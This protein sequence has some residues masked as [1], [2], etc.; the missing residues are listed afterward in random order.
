[1]VFSFQASPFIIT[2]P[3]KQHLEALDENDYRFKMSSFSN[4]LT[5]LAFAN[6]NQLI[7]AQECSS[8][9]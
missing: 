4:N 1:M 7:K 3:E 5:D 9:K 6:T 2:P 8:G